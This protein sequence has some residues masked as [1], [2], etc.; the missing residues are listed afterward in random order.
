MA[1]KSLIDFG[2]AANLAINLGFLQ[3]QVERNDI[4][5]KNAQNRERELEVQQEGQRVDTAKKA[6]DEIEK[7][8]S[9]PSLAGNRQAQVDLLL[10]QGQVMQ[11]GLGVNVPLPSRDELM[12]GY[13]QVDK[14]MKT[15]F[16]P[17]ASV[18]EKRAV[19]Q[20]AGVANP[21]WWNQMM[22]GMKKAGDVSQQMAEFDM[23]VRA[24]EAKLQA[25]N[26]K[27]ARYNMQQT[28]YTEH[29]SALG[30]TT[31]LAT[32]KEFQEHFQKLIRMTD[33][34][35]NPNKVAQQA[36]L[37]INPKFKEKWEKA[38]LNEKLPLSMQLLAL[39][40]EVR[41]RSAA[42]KE[43][44]AKTGEAPMD[45]AEELTGYGAV[46]RARLIQQDWLEDPFNKQKW[47]NLKKA[48]QDIRILNGATGK[49]ISEVADARLGLMQQKFDQA[50]A[51]KAAESTLQEKYIQYVNEKM[52]D[53]QA[54]GL[55]IKDTRKLH[56]GVPFDATK[57]ENPNKK[58]KT[59][60]S[61]KMGQS[62]VDR[63]LK[64]I[65][66]SQ[67]VIDFAHE[68]RDRIQANP[69]IVGRAGQAGAAFAGSAQQLRALAGLDP[70]ASQF[71]NTK[72][73]DEAE[74]FQELLVYMQARSMDPSGPLDLKVVENARKVVG[75]LNTL[76]TGPQQIL[77]K[78]DV[79]VTNAERNIRRARRNL[80]G[81]GSVAP[82][83]GETPQEVP[84]EKP[85]TEMSDEELMQTIL[86]GTLQ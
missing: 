38:L 68:L 45:L 4:Y 66:S 10:T 62:E 61:L 22:D 57:V 54:L 70:G 24:N 16:D 63:N 19:M 44:Q 65:D 28:F 60:V 69:S 17:N 50:T 81:G 30:R 55:A 53:A 40:D 5:L 21:A 77:N 80:R 11:K 13:E 74:A 82:Y 6:Y 84:A 1:Q 79:T 78:L 3:Q 25:L 73:R 7:M 42:L 67:G 52:D 9:H 56:P 37:S 64:L 20:E 86:R 48:E 83:L 41:S 59:E 46:E 14:L 85:L 12:G 27:N 58:G 51:I 32:D 2:G 72:T 76:T 49:K 75:D 47:L 33:K 35:G 8:K 31:G 71:L 23:K 18:D 26:L 39:G 15:M 36:Y 29:M 43:A 34:D